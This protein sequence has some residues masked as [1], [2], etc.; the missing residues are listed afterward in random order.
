M[1]AVSPQ[2]VLKVLEITDSANLHRESVFI[3]LA[4]A[5]EGGVTILPDGRLKITC[6]ND[7][8]ENWVK[9]FRSQLEK[10]DLSLV[11]H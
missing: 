10:M 3:P 7:D 2:Q 6:P 4:T 5:A 9:G 11:K 8:F 1:K